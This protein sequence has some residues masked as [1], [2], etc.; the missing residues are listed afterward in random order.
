MQQIRLMGAWDAE[1]GKYLP[2]FNPQLKGFH[3]NGVWESFTDSNGV[4]WAGGDI[5][6]SLGAYGVQN[7]VGFARFAPRD[8]AAP[9][10][11]TNL[12]VSVDNATDKLSWTKSAESGVVYQIIRDNRVVGSTSESTFS[13][14]HQDGARYFVRAMDS[15]GNISAST[16]VVLSPVTPSTPA[17]PTPEIISQKVVS[18]GDQ[19]QYK[20]G[21]AALDSS[22][23]DVATTETGWSS[24]VSTLGWGGSNLATVIDRGDKSPI[25]VYFRKEISVNSLDEVKKFQISTVA[26]DGV[27][28]YLNGKEVGRKN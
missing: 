14:N 12:Q 20:L 7:T 11:P 23:K 27:V 1:T 17:T 24:G 10:V 21:L 18:T 3:G 9:M 19:W 26:D 22:W 25:S 5:A 15:A 28:V 13:L 8:S 16:P 6:T 4:L 2:Q